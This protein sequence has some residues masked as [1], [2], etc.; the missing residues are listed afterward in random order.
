[1]NSISLIFLL[2]VFTSALCPNSAPPP[3][4]TRTPV[5][6][7]CGGD[8]GLTTG[9]CQ[10]VVEAFN[11]SP[12]FELS[13]GDMPGSLVV[14]IPT[15]VDWKEIGKRTRVMYKVEFTSTDDRKLAT[16]KG[17]CWEGEFGTCANQVIK[18]ARTEL[19]RLQSDNFWRQ[20]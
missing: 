7:W 19:S 17:T 1:M 5:E 13:S 9:V 4:Q 20:T 16:R 2:V 12:D 18:Y 8:D 15:N 10:A 11:S 14:T 6:V 3:E